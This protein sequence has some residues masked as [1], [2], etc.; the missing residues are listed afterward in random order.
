MA[1]TGYGNLD[2]RSRREGF[3]HHFLK[4]VD[5]TA[6]LDV[7]DAYSKRPAGEGPPPAERA[8]SLVA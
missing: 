1:V 2:D 7:L 8:T 6:L 4:P 3:D 5:P